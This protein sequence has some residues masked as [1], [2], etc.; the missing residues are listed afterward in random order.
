MFQKCQNL[1]RKLFS[2]DSDHRKIL[3]KQKLPVITQVTFI[4]PTRSPEI[5]TIQKRFLYAEEANLNIFLARLKGA[6]Q[7]IP[8]IIKQTID[9][10]MREQT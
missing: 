6:L 1:G 9:S 5:Y 10:W 8:A 7:V 4:I 3:W 2:Q